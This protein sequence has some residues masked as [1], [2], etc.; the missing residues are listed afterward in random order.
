MF[1]SIMVSAKKL[2]KQSKESS[3]VAHKCHN[4]RKKLQN[5]ELATK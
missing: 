1:K 3:A 2:R 4:K 5:E